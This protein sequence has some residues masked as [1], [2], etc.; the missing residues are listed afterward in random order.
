MRHRPRLTSLLAVGVAGVLVAGLTYLATNRSA[1]AASGTTA[2]R[3]G[4]FVVDTPNVVRRANVVFGRANIVPGQFVALGNGPLG[5]AVWAAS[6]F[7]AQLNRPDTFPDRRSPGQVVIPGLSRLTSAPDFA[8]YLDVYDGMLHESGGGMTLTAYVRADTAQLVVDVTGADPGSTQTAQVQLWSGRAPAASVSGPVA[9]LAESWVDNSGTGASGQTFGTLVG[10]SA[11]GRGLVASTPSAST[12]QVSFQPRTDGSFRVIAAAPAW[13]GGDALATAN[14]V[15]NNDADKPSST[16]TAA[17][18]AWW[19]TYWSSAG[20]IRISSAD[21]T[22][23]YIENVRTLYLYY[24]AAERGTAA[25]PGSQAGVADLFNFSQDHQDWFPAG[26]WFWNLRMQVQANLSAGVFGLDDPVFQLYRGNVANISAWT[27]ANMP[28][29]AGLC[30]PET[31]R[32]NGNGTWLG[33]MGNSSCNST[34]QP[35]YNSLTITTGAEVGLWTWQRY[36]MSDDVSFLRDNYPVMSGAATFLLSSASVGPDGFLHTRANAH[37]TQWD[38]ADPVTDVLAMQAL[39]PVVVKAAQALGVDASLV[40]QLTAAIPK[41]PPLPRT[42][43]ATK[44]QLLTAA[45]DAAGT[46]MIGWSAQPTADMRNSENLGLE[47]VWPYNTI[48]DS[49]PLTALARRTYT[50]RSYVNGNDW[51]FDPLHAARLGLATEV[52]STLVN[53]ATKYQAYPSG[54]ASF[55]G[56]PAAEPYVE[57]AGVLAAT[58]SEALV[59]DYDGLLRIAPAWPSDWSGDGTVAIQHNS[60]AY[61]QM[62]NGTP[63]TVA[64]A[65]GSDTPITVRSPW[66]GQSVTVV[67]GTGATVVGPQSS[68]TFTIP[69]RSG[70]SYLVELTSAPTTSL[71]FAPVSGAPASAA[72]HLGPASIGL[73]RGQQQQQRTVSLRAHANG[74]LVTA[75]NAGAAP[76][77]ANRTAIGTWETFQLTRN[78]DGGI[79]LRALANNGYVCAEHAGAAPL[80]ANRTAI[81][82]WEEFDLITA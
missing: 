12:A 59:Q 36:L 20:L 26:Y 42:D 81:G 32:F 67:D 8:G 46:D 62:R 43:T 68:A 37:E 34:V 54:L 14:A 10:V 48:G 79:S 17:H 70:R 66:P 1:A 74:M 72:R 13:T 16:L 55:T 3:D 82:T 76:L 5:A 71:P 53:A 38:V 28:G 29:R 21:G 64:I 65:S 31:M 24:A 57:Q 63:V 9:V 39:F 23:D 52:K 45:A 18:L 19:H 58:V 30:V 6:G 11:G 47:A 22:G 69:A 35:S 41:I 27:K 77:V 75:E 80:V 61:V 25:Y 7:T 60:K 73:D 78:P 2:W 49:D 56:T 44:T 50:S 33:G 4:A 51:S 15:L 40:S